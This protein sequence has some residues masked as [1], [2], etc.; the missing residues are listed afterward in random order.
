MADA[1]DLPAP[2]PLAQLADEREL[3]LFL[4]FDGT[5]VDLAHAPGAI[6]VP[7]GLPGRLRALADRLGGRLALVT[8]RSLDDLAI[9]CPIEGIACAGSHGDDRRSAAGAAIGAPAAALP[10]GAFDALHAAARDLGLA[11]EA[12]THG[13]ALHYRTD[14]E[15]GGAALALAT[16]VAGRFGLAVKEGKHVVEL[17]RPGADKGGAVRAFMGLPPFAGAMPV[18][19]GDDLTDEDGIAACIEL[20]GFGILVGDRSPTGARYRLPGVP[21]VYRWLNL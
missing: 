1:I 13:A 8:G 21:A 2:P 20:G 12:K 17:T 14:P 6:A 7:R 11:L 5:L 9:H 18:F 19:V 16:E 4:D 10:Q 3:A 15:R